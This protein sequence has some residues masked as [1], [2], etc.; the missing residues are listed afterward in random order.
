MVMT[1]LPKKVD[2]PLAVR[3]P[4]APVLEPRQD[5]LHWWER[6][7]T[8]NPGVTEHDGKVILLYRAYDDFRI[9][10]LG[11][12]RSSEGVSFE[13]YDRPA[14]D[15]DPNDP[16]ERLGI[17]DPRITKIGLTY[18]IVHTVASYK[19]IGEPADVNG[20]FDY[21]PWRVRIAMHTT[22]D[23]K[24][25]YHH[26]VIL[27]DVPAK[28]ACLLP[29]K[30]NDRFGLYYREFQGNENIARLAFT[31]DFRTW[32]DVQEV[33]LPQS[34]EW[35]GFKAGYGSQPIAIPAGFLMVYHAVDKNQVYRLGLLLFDRKDPARVVWYSNPILEPELPYEKVGYVPNVVY[36]C[37]A[38]I[39]GKELWI[40]YGAADRV[41]GRAIVS[42]ILSLGD[43]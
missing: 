40:Y 25:F 4:A 12:A 2:L 22:K 17:E 27:P 6:N 16:D 11:I 1:E 10:R 20:T 15:T 30:I 5:N 24:T 3:S 8:F 7:G 19:R 28:N 23:F 41:I 43:S 34:E 18:Y 31:K 9:S 33:M 13:R 42:N 38:L 32:T 35:Q 36:T 37:G 29:E 26:D 14:I 39:R 21:I